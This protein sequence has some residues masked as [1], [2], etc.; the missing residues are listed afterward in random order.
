MDFVELNPDQRREAINTRQ[1]FNDWRDALARHQACRGSMVWAQTKGH[2]YLLRSAY[3]K[4]GQRRQTS[5]GPRSPGTE[6]IKAEFSRA[7][8]EAAERLAGLKPV[9]ARQAAVNRALGLGRV[10]LLGARILRALEEHGLLGTGIR[11]VGANAI[12]AYEAAAGVHIDSGLTTTEDV[13]LLLDSRGGLAF[14]VTEE[15]PDASL[16]K[17]LQRVDKSFI[18]SGQEFRAVNRDGYLVD[19]IKPLPN[20]PWKVESACIGDDP[21]DLGAIEIEGLA[22]HESAPAFEATAIDERG[23]P[24]RMVASDPR[25]FAAHKFWLSK[26]TDREPI[27]RL[28]DGDQARAIGALVAGWLPHL[29]FDE[30]ELRMLPKELI[31]KARPLFADTVAKSEP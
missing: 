21:A 10:P 17:I 1:R 7:R 8:E 31:A 16:L 4:Q 28:R 2:D 15:T 29:P 25:V 30:E 22:W 20:P 3:D 26:R 18:R 6:R 24:L 12:Y 5:L 19:L 13:D 27:E 14:S 9:M 11:V 23:E